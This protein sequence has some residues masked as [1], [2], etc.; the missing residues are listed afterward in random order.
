MYNASKRSFEHCA[1][2]VLFDYIVLLKKLQFLEEDSQTS[3]NLYSCHSLLGES[4][5][6]K[7]IVKGQINNM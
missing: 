1:L 5:T 4:K 2:R 6:F 7:K 3:A